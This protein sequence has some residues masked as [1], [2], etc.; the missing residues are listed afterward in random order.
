LYCV[1]VQ[2]VSTVAVHQDIPAYL[3]LISLRVFSNSSSDKSVDKYVA[4]FLKNSIS[5]SDIAPFIL[6]KFAIASK[7]FNE[8]TFISVTFLSVQAPV[9]ILLFHSH[10]QTASVQSQE[11]ISFTLSTI[12][13]ASAF[14]LFV[15]GN[16]QALK[17]AHSFSVYQLSLNVSFHC[18]SNFVTLH[19]K[20]ISLSVYC[21]QISCVV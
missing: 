5:L 13:F 1:E 20:A 14:C 8:A 11:N 17:L 2:V 10:T 12:I 15:G 16:N 18:L 3:F 9:H 21:F 7:S 6:S 4:V 19:N